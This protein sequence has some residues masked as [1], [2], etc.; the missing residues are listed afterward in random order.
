[1]SRLGPLTLPRQE[2]E[3][4][5]ELQ[6]APLYRARDRCRRRGWIHCGCGIVVFG[7]DVYRRGS[8]LVVR[9]Q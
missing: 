8:R 6:S 5:L 4:R 7:V 2:Q 9:G 3:L 1:M